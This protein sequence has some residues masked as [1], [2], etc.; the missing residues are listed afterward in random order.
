MLHMRAGV[1]ATRRSPEKVSRGIPSVTRHR[2]LRSRSYIGFT[3]IAR[4][5]Y[6][7]TWSWNRLTFATRTTSTK[8]WIASG[9]ARL[10][11]MFPNTFA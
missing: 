6:R 1:R 3:K 2:N 10:T 11:R 4:I 8:S 7:M 5:G 9:L